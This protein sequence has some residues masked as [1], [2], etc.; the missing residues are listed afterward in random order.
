M[1]FLKGKIQNKKKERGQVP[2]GLI[3]LGRPRM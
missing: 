2:L 1:I 3:H